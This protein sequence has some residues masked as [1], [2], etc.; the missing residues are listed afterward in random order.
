MNMD[1]HNKQRNRALDDAFFENNNK[2]KDH[3][4]FPKKA[5]KETL[6]MEIPSASAIASTIS[7]PTCNYIT[8]IKFISK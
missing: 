2:L 4:P 3:K 6:L 1:Q 8:F 7:K 5:L